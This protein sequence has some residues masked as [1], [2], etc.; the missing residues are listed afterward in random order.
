MGVAATPADG[1]ILGQGSDRL[2]RMVP[3][4]ASSLHG[5]SADHLLVDLG[6][7]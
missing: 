7:G 1:A 5:G 6:G 4:I 3:E 2:F